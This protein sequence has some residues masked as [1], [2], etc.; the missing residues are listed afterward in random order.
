M[1]GLERVGIDDNFFDLGG[2]SLLAAR[3]ISRARAML[4]VELSIRALFESP[5]VA[6]LATRL[7]GASRTVQ[8]PLRKMDRPEAIPLSFAQRRLWFLDQLEGPS[9]TYNIRMALRLEGPLDVA[10]LRA[11]L[12]DLAER[13]ESLRTVFPDATEAPEQV[14]LGAG[15]AAPVLTVEET[16]EAELAE[17]LAEAAAYCFDLERE[18]PDPRGWLFRLGGDRNVLLV[19]HHIAADGWSLGP[20]GRDLARAYAARLPPA[21]PGVGLPLPAQYAEYTL[22]QHALLGSESDADSAIARQL[23]YWRQAAGGSADVHGAANRPA[24]AGGPSYRGAQRAADICRRRCTGSC[25]AWRAAVRASLFMVLEAGLAALLPQAAAGAM[26]LCS[27][28]RSRAAA[29]LR[30]TIW[31]ASSSTRWCCAPTCRAIRVS[32]NCWLGC[33][34]PTWQRMRIRICRSNGW[35]RF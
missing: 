4:G 5:T 13:H 6:E 9:P 16:D 14:I 19:L 28:A 7:E 34:S 32:A 35:W 18:V 24:S 23:A 12:A 15:A 8:T 31:S 1:L 33:G 10:A 11:G 3:L 25:A 20:L 29:M 27:A 30:W 26:I 17:R 21:G 2:H 22:W